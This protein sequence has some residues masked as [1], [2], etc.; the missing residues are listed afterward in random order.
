MI[1]V[2]AFYRAPNHGAT[3]PRANGK[4]KRETDTEGRGGGR[5]G[6]TEEERTARLTGEKERQT[7]FSVFPILTKSS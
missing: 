1:G 7:T 5:G 3:K 6:E 4:K 2:P